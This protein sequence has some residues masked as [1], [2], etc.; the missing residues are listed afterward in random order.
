MC[1]QM[2]ENA[3]FY[4]FIVLTILRTNTLKNDKMV[5]NMF[6]KCFDCVGFF[7]AIEN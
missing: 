2:A 6:K 5:S 3:P 7:M 1:Q 4:I